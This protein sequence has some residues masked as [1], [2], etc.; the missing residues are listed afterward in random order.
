MITQVNNE[1]TKAKILSKEFKQNFVNQ[2]TGQ[3][4][5]ITEKDTCA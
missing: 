4:K 3:I 2:Y 1:K 5:D